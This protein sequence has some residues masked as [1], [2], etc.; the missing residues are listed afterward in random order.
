MVWQLQFL[1]QPL[2][3]VEHLVQTLVRVTWLIDAYNLYLVKLVQAVQ[4]ANILTV[5]TSL[6][7]EAG[8]VSTALDREILLVKNH[9]TEDVGYRNLSS[10]DEEEV[11]EIRVIHLTLLVWQLTCATTRILVYYIRRLNLKISALT[12]LIEEECLESTL[13]ASHLTDIYREAG[14]GNLHTEVEVNKIVFLQEIPMAESILAEVWL[15]ATFFY[16]H[17][18]SRILTLR[19][20]FARDVRDFEQLIGHIVL[21]FLHDLFQSLS[22]SLEHSYLSLCALSFLFLT[23][24]H[25]GTNLLGKLVSLLLVVIQLLLSFTTNLVVLQNFLYGLTS[26]W[27]MLLFKTFN[28]TFSFFTDEFKCKHIMSFYLIIY[29]L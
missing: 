9:I 11:V 7:T 2:Y 1:Q 16:D 21:C 12:S 25:K 6:T 5:A 18:V 13:E 22:V 23:F 27:K 26:I 29:Y 8:R 10:R 4:A 3:V 20:Q 19:N 15:F 17:V 14:T 24:L 28:Y